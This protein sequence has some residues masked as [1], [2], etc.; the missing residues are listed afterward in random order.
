MI[1]IDDLFSKKKE[2][3]K[4]VEHTFK[5][6]KAAVKQVCTGCGLVMLRNEATNKAVKLGCM[7]HV[8]P[9]TK[10]S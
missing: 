2:K 9:S 1:T 6:N 4:Y 7:F 5:F 8:H 10:R 3:Y